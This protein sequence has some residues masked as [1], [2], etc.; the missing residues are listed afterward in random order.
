L[1]VFGNVSVS[2]VMETA[3]QSHIHVSSMYKV[4]AITAAGLIGFF[5]IMKLFNLA[6]MVEFRFLNIDILLFGVRYVLL[7]ERAENNGRL[8]YLNGMM[9]GFMTAVLAAVMFSVFI[10]IYLK[11]DRSFMHYL[12]IT[13]PFGKS[14]TPASAALIILIEGAASGAILSFAFN[15]ILNR[16]EAQG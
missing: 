2:K 13:Q 10:F 8:E 9:K 12:T 14:L 6:T 11:L 5:L 16:D 4:S 3:I 7:R 15:H 1:R